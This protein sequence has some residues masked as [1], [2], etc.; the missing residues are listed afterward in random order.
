VRPPRPLN[1]S[2]FLSL[3]TP[4]FRRP[5]AFA[6]NQES[7]GRQ[8]AAHEVQ[9]VVVPDHVGHGVAEGLYGRVAWYAPV[10]R[11]KYVNFLCDDDVLAADDVV[12]K[13]MA[14]AASRDFPA[15]IIAPV[16]KGSVRLPACTPTSEP[17]CGQVDL[18]SYIVRADVWRQHLD[19]YGRRYEGDYDHAKATWDAGHVPAY[20]DVLWAIGGASNGRPEIDY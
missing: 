20:F 6:K 18:T 14:F 5:A 1:P 9:Q 15:V 19:D 3:Y 13:L 4:L 12:A 2:P 10:M 8:T 11:G 17:I 16:I 7:I